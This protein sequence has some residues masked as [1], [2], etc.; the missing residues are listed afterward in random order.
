MWSWKQTNVQ[1][2]QSSRT[3]TEY[4]HWLNSRKVKNILHWEWIKKKYI[5]FK[6]SQP[7]SNNFRGHLN[8]A[9]P[10]FQNIP[11]LYFLA[12]TYPSIRRIFNLE[13]LQADDRMVEILTPTSGFSCVLCYRK[14]NIISDWL[15]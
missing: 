8:L 12:I 14:T 6:I 11:S 10:T 7:K 2:S 9:P 4:G 3:G 13:H 5:F 1:V 15:L